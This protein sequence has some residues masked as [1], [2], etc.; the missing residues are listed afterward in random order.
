M[1]FFNFEDIIFFCTF[2]IINHEKHFNSIQSLNGRPR[3]EIKGREVS[4]M[5]QF[6]PLKKKHVN[7]EKPANEIIEEELPLKSNK[8]YED[9]KGLL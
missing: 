2:E 1:D 3:F 5:K 7:L 9:V 6:V 4:V 8:K